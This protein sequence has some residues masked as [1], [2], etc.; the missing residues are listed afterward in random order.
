MHIRWKMQKQ[1]IRGQKQDIEGNEQHI[2]VPDVVSNK[3]RQHIQVLFEKFGYDK[4]F[5]RT[6]VMSVLSIT[7]SPA[8][9]LIKKMLD[10][11]IIY[12]MNGKG[13]GKYLSTRE[14]VTS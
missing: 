1:D 6:E 5:G 8:S 4:I 10:L 9:S 11:G 13:K 7:A 14:D 2:E 3:T 12:L